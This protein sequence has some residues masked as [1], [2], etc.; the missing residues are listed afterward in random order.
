MPYLIQSMM[1]NL[2][3]QSAVVRDTLLSNARY[4]VKQNEEFSFFLSPSEI[5]AVCVSIEDRIFCSYCA[6]ICELSSEKSVEWTEQRNGAKIISFDYLNDEYIICAVLSSGAV[7]IVDYENGTVGYFAIPTEICSARWAPDFHVLLIASSEMLY[8]VTRQFDILNEQP[9]NSSRSGREELMTVG[10]GSKETQFQGVGGRKQPRKDDDEQ[11]TAVS[12]YDKGRVL[13]A[14][15]GDANYVVVSYVNKETS[16]RRFS[17][18]DH[19]GELVSHL[20]QVSNVE[21]TLA[22]RPTGNLIATSRC[23]GDKREIIFYERNGQKR[24]KFE[25]GPHQGTIIDWMGWNIDGN[26]LCVQSRDLMGTAQEVSFWCV[27]N[28]NWMLKYRISVDNGFLLAC[29]HE[30]NP[31]QFCYVTQNGRA[32]FIDF[33]FVY[34]FCNGIVLS[35]A[36]CNVRVT[37]LKAAPIPPP[38]CHY[39]L[40]FPNV[41]CEIAQ[42]NDSAAFLLADHSLLACMIMFS[43]FELTNINELREGKFD[44]CAE[45][46]T[47]DLPKECICYNLC[48]DDSN[49]LSA[50]V[51]SSYCSLYSLN[52]KNMNRK[53]SLCLYSIEKPFIWHSHFTGGFILQG[54]DGEWFSIKEDKEKNC[55]LETRSLFGAGSIL[56]C[57]RCLP[58]KDSVFGIGK[59]NDL[60]MNGRPI[61][62]NVGSYTVDQNYLL[63]LTLVSNSSSSKLQIAELKNSLTT[64]KEINYKTSRAVERGAMLIGHETG[65]TRVWL[66]MPRGNLETIHFKELLVNKLKELLDNML[67]KDAAI[68]M[69]KHRIDMNL[70]YDHNPEASYCGNYYTLFV[71]DIGSAELLNLFVASLNN[72]NVTDGI[73]LDNYSD[74]NHTRPDKGA[75]KNGKTKVQDVC[76]AIRE[77]ILNLDDNLITDLYTTVISTYLKEQP[78]QVSKALSALREQSLKLP[79]GA[80]LEKKWIAYVS[81]L[82]PNENLFNV[83]LS[84]YDLSLALAVAENSQMDPKE[85]LPLLTDFQ[86]Q[87]PP[88]YQKFKI[89]IHLGMFK[90]AIQ[91]LSELDDRWIEAEACELFANHLMNKRRFE[92]AAVLFK[93]ANNITLAL[94]CYQ[95]VQNWK[96]VVECGQIMNMEGEMLSDLL[97][98]MVPHFESKGKFADIAEILSFIDKKSNRMQIVEYYCKADAWNLATNFAFGNDE[99]IKIVSEAASVRCKQILKNIGNWEDLLE[100]YCCRLEIVRQTKKNSLKAIVKRF[101]DQD[102]PMSEVFSETSSSVSNV[103]KLSVASTASAYRRKHVE[104]K[105]KVLREGSQYEDAALL[106]A[107]KDIVLR[108]DSQQDELILLLPTLVAVDALEEA[109]ALHIQFVTLI[110]LA[111]KII[112]TAWPTHISPHMI[113]GP[114]REIYRDE[115]GVIKLPEENSMPDRIPLESELMRPQIRNV[116]WQLEICS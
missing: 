106:N 78:P 21:E 11:P 62:K 110:K 75:L 47:T 26:I 56:H 88:A 49:Q 66:Q 16:F 65:G 43:I 48:W 103:S 41:V 32:T 13:L 91:N 79:D 109:R 4:E 94:Q 53:E 52:L 74:N 27:S 31:N 97:Q 92:E 69:K 9:L 114:L 35:I 67:F 100:Q 51:A 12:K 36:G 63:A 58:T 98:K 105:K 8:F 102:L 20:Q 85:Y 30:S 37:D 99:L 115:N 14:W 22:Y 44:E 89:D 107:L 72:D 96:G 24:S 2:K 112:G 28:Y 57:C 111:H 87:S 23:D 61:L 6:G 77:Y 3:I 83:S 15:D 54:I 25:Y 1:R 42:Y 5:E 39:E 108:I 104:K 86:T 29:W 33:D 17:V 60:V 90:R 84:T 93:R 34:N 116:P 38:M 50:I 40:T 70:F 55:Y 18:F 81:L 45:Y 71:E 19:E 101:E 73:Y 82:A 10:W 113:P 64:D 80:K 59:T 46:D 68:I 95:S 7:L 76:T